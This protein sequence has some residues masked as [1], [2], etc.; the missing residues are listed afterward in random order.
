MKQVKASYLSIPFAIFIFFASSYL[1]TAGGHFYYQDGYHKYLVV[2][3]IVKGEGGFHKQMYVIGKEGKRTESYPIGSSLW[4]T[5]FYILGLI[6]FNLFHA[7]LPAKI[8]ANAMFITSFFTMLLNSFAVA[9]ICALFYMICRRLEYPSRTSFL[10]TLILGFATM[11]WPFSKFCFSEPQAAF[12][13]LIFFYLCLGLSEGCTVKKI[14]CAG[15]CY[16]CAV[17]TK[18]EVLFLLPAVVSYI[19]YQLRAEAANR[20]GQYVVCFLMV[21]ALFCMS[22]LL[23]NQY[24]FGHWFAFGRYQYFINRVPKKFMTILGYVSACAILLKLYLQFP[25]FASIIRRW[26]ALMSM[27]FFTWLMLTFILNPKTNIVAFRVLFSSGK[28]I[29]VFAPVLIL[30]AIGLKRFMKDHRAEGLFIVGC[31]TLYLLLLHSETIWTWGSRYY[32]S[33][34]PFFMMPIAGFLSDFPKQSVVK[35]LACAVIVFSLVIQILGIS[36]NYQDSLNTI[37]RLVAQDLEIAIDGYDTEA[38]HVFSRLI[39]DPAYSP[40]VAQF[41]VLRG[42]LTHQYPDFDPSFKTKVGV[43]EPNNW[44]IDFWWLYLIKQ[45]LPAQMIYAIV[46]LLLCIS[47]GTFRILMKKFF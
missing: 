32:V 47:A 20:R 17:I 7:V 22:I 13:L 40:I 9:G 45:G 14:V 24:R 34:V 42:V 35:G 33:L 15:L 10:A 12:F 27:V 8:A 43:R 4:M 2:D 23:W 39:Y 3:S 28:S 41:L 37:D 1:L 31:F 36:V 6:N 46:F 29:F 18:Y 26:T 30:S 38:M 44:M 11:M 5:P 16:G 25:R 21:L 19:F